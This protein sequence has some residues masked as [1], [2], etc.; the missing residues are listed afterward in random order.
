MALSMMSR[1][2]ISI[3]RL[4]PRRSANEPRELMNCKSCRKRKVR[5]GKSTRRRYAQTDHPNHSDQVQQIKAVLRG[6]P[7]FCR[8]VHIRFVGPK[9]RI[10]SLTLARCGAEKEG[11]QNRRPGGSAEES[12]WVGKKIEARRQ[13]SSRVAGE[14][15]FRE[16]NEKAGTR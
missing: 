2:Q 9:S 1:P 16:S 15:T 6:M 10:L 13:E 4:P 7:G 3:D 8:S 5:F 12:R 14:G 11:A